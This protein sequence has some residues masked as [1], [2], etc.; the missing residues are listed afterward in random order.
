MSLLNNYSHPDIAVETSVDLAHR[1]VRDTCPLG[2]LRG[3]VVL[4]AYHT[5][6]LV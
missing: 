4:R 1:V 3:L 2:R 6:Y 5:T